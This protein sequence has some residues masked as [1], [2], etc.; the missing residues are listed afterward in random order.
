[1]ET[2]CNFIAVTVILIAILLVMSVDFPLNV[3]QY[4][5]FE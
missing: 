3:F 1:V 2:E 4:F 5:L